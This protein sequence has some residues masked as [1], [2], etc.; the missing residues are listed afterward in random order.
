[1][2]RYRVL[3]GAV[4]LIGGLVVGEEVLGTTNLLKL[5]VGGVVKFLACR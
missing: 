3:C 4:L 5:H 1:V 2:V